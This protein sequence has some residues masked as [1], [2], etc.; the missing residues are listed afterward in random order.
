MAVVVY[1]TPVRIAGDGDLH[2]KVAAADHPREQF[3]RIGGLGVRRRQ[4]QL[5]E[6][7][8]DAVAQ[9][10]ASVDGVDLRR[11]QRA[12]HDQAHAAVVADQPLDAAG[13]Q[14][15]RAGIEVAG[16]PVVACSVV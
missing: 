6:A 14:R 8:F 13:R 10:F 12:T 5:D 11:G 9:C 3:E 7:A 16:Q 4:R 15:E 1:G 2:I